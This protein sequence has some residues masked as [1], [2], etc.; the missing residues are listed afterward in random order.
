MLPHV[1]WL[2]NSGTPLKTLDGKTVAILKFNPKEQQSVFSDWAKHFREHYCKD[3]EIDALRNG[4]GLSR[5]NYLKEIKFPDGDSAPG[6]SIRSGDFG[7]FLSQTT[8][9]T[10]WA[11]SFRGPGTNLS[12]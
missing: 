6:P 1:K 12:R 2:V 7:R 8:S 4:T 11:I 10:L 3:S 5:A 9:N